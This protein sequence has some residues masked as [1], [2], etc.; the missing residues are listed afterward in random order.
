M[1]ETLWHDLRYGARMLGGSP[2]FSL[3]AIASIAVGVGANAAMF[4]VADTLVLRPL[5]V[6]RPSEIVNVTAVVPRSG[7]ASPVTATVSHPDYVDVRDHSNSFAS[8]MAYQLVVTGFAPSAEQPSQRTFGLAVSGNFF[9]TLGVQPALGHSFGVDADRVVGRDAVVV[10]DDSLWQRQFASDPGVIGRRV[11]I[12]GIDMTVIGVMPAG[13]TGPDQFVLPSFYT[14][15]A[16]LPALN[17]AAGDELTRRDLR[18]L[19]LKGRLNSGVSIARASEDVRLVA[20]D[21]AKQYPDTNRNHSLA[22]RTEFDARV[23][24]R[25]A[26]AVTAFGVMALAFAVLLVACANVAGLLASR[27]P[28]RAREIALRMAIGA[29]RPR[30]VRQLLIESLLIAVAG[31]LVGLL[32]AQAIIEVFQ[33]LQ[34]PSDVPL[35]LAFA[36][37]ERVLIVAMVIACASAIL[38]SLLPAWQT[39][40]VDLTATLKSVTT[41]DRARL[42]G[43]HILVA[44]QVAMSLILL[45][46]AVFLFRGF[47][48]EIERGP[49]F[50]TDHI[51]LASFSPDM[52]RYDAARTDAFYKLLVDRTRALPRVRS[53]ALT[54]SPPMDAI[55]IENTP[56]A[57]EGFQ[58]PSGTDHVN[59]RSARIDEGYFDAIGV[60]LIRGRAFRPADAADAPRVAV[61]NEAFAR[62]YWPGQDP[63]GKRFR[64]LERDGTWFEIVGVAATTKYRS[65]SEGPT[66]F[67]Y[68]SRRQRPSALSTLLVET[69]GDA[70]AMAASVRQVVTSIDPNMP[71]FDVRTMQDLYDAS[72]I[73]LSTLLVRIVG[74][75]GS[76]ALVLALTGLYGLMA[77]S[78]S[79]R[80]REI[81]IRMAVGAHPG[82]ILR[83]VLDHGL[84]LT[85]VGGAAGV[86]GS[87]AM[88][89]VLRA[90]MPFPA[91]S[92][93][94]ITPYATAVPA[95]LAVTFLAAYIPARRAAR[96]DPLTTLRSE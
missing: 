54:S 57:P 74:G 44:G 29:G 77:Y 75:M 27:A 20:A 72:A 94:D 56:V 61:V 26:L 45:T 1:L 25:P 80:T 89:G 79:R 47:Q 35:K 49:G 90:L 51:L 22:V 8:L 7:F 18:N 23:S 9:D 70:A 92:R 93:F 73:G 31:G 17:S 85:A 64:L 19:M 10:I 76:I 69:D 81:G 65:L 11:R 16:M 41:S 52:I 53:V 4:S 3:V 32:F 86:I 28:V 6:S 38:S 12:G 15:L 21:L 42:W 33:R 62:R 68:Y 34:V 82:S 36:L 83:M 14:P 39:T 96:I 46:V 30:L 63:T 13:F 40:R 88:L 48:G 58:F 78:V 71:M 91:M 50:R 5:S 95:L 2:A 67:I 55:S 59:V 84:W 37:D 87:I 60:R 43:R 66:E 24:A